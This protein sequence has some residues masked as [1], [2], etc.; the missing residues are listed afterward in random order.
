MNEFTKQALAEKLL[1]MADDELI[2]GHRN[3]EWTGHAPILEEDIAF[4]NIAQ[5]EIGHAVIWL[6]LRE[7]LTGE[8]ADP[9]VFFRR[10][11][12][13]GNTQF[14]ELP[15]GDWA[16]SMMRQYLFDTWEM[17][18]L[19]HLQ[20]SSYRPVAEAAAKMRNEEL[21]HFRHTSAWLK[22]LGLGTDESNG[23][24]QHALNDLWPYVHQLFVLLP[25]EAVLI[26][27]GI[28]PDQTAVYHQWQEIVFPFLI[29]VNLK[30]PTEQPPDQSPPTTQRKEHTP[31]LAALLRE[32][33]EV[34]RLDPQAE[35]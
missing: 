8:T 34:A 31:H 12:E 6:Q 22:R 28:V 14:V 23:R 13:Y 17:I 27:T 35:W 4:A 29:E 2:L 33:Q 7:A 18:T 20:K 24:L 26:E 21:Y 30:Q 16:F 19:T 32:M 10:A 15:K 5:D 25:N 9:L 1:S 11:D 3:S